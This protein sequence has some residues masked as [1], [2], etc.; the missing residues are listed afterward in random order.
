[1]RLDKYLQAKYP[2][3]SRTDLQKIIA[4]GMVLLNG[5]PLPKSF[6]VDENSDL[7]FEILQL[8]VK[9]ESHLEPENI[10]LNI[11]FEDEHLAVIN[12]PRNM[13]MHPGNGISKKTLA[14]ALLWHFKNLSQVN[15]PLRPGI[16][17][18]LDKDTPGLLVVAKTD[19]A[20]REL[21]SQLEAR[22]LERTYRAVIWGILRDQEGEID[23]P[24]E[25]DPRNRLKMSVQ[26]EGKIA[27]T[28]YKT[29]ETYGIAS[30]VEFKLNTGRTHQIRVHARYLGNPVVGD[31]LYE[32]RE[33]SAKR[34]DTIY[35]PMAEKLLEFAPAQLLQSYKIKFKHPKT[36]ET[37]EFKIEEDESLK[38][39]LDFLRK[40]REK[41]NMPVQ[42]FEPPQIFANP[43]DIELPPEEIEEMPIK[44]RPTRAERYAATKIKRAL[45]KEKKLMLQTKGNP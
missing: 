9:T 5:K 17:H 1:M 38:K 36:K 34:I 19:L 27:K 24:I 11:V 20:H 10:P 6:D 26:A 13:T 22:I 29:L 7:P 39:A 43:E 18:R 23:A 12:K 30:L 21:T 35:K 41:S 33:E 2:E 25:R 4:N 44:E 8:P 32:G 37:M 45:K 15:G 14:A 16:L 40:N 31:P 3:Y 42:L 28:N